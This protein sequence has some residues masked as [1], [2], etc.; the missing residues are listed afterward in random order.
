VLIQELD[1]NQKKSRAEEI[2]D[3]MIK[4]DEIT[5]ISF[6][7]IRQDWID[8]EMHEIRLIVLHWQDRSSDT[9]L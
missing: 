5:E 8:E 7:R 4:I 1:Q 2:F 3:Q 6:P 9:M